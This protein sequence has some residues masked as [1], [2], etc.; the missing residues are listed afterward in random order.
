MLPSRPMWWCFGIVATIVLVAFLLGGDD[1]DGSGSP[2]RSRSIERRAQEIAGKVDSL[3][4]YRALQRRLEDTDWNSSRYDVLEEAVGIASDKV[5]AWQFLPDV[6]VTTPLS[7]LKRAYKVY[8]LTKVDE[9][10]AELGHDNL[11]HELRGDDEPEPPEEEFDFVMKFRK[12]VESKVTQRTK[13]KKINEL[14]ASQPDIA[15]DWLLDPKSKLTPGDQW[16]LDTLKEGGLPLAHELYAEGYTTPE[17][18]LEIDL[19]EFRARNGVGP[20]KVEALR[21]YQERVRESIERPSRSAETG[22]SA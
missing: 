14:C 10:K 20:K 4:K 6:D 22:E 16:F 13:I 18:C 2:K 15:E 5:L 8:S 1:D 12:A 3:A 7:V 9:A 19:E 11:W 17:K 21:E